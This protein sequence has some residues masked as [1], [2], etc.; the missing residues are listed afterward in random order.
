MEF[1]EKQGRI[2]FANGID[3]WF[4]PED[5][6]NPIDH[7]PS[8]DDARKIA[9]TIAAAPEMLEA[10]EC[11]MRIVD[12]WGPVYITKYLPSQEGECF[13]LNEMK[14]RITDAIK[15]AKGEQ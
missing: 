7:W 14:D 11:A 15:K 1:E 4:N 13:A 3:I 5:D 12:L 9:K 10:L 8:I 6:K 2:S